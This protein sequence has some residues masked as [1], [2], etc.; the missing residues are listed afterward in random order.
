MDLSRVVAQLE[1]QRPGAR[2]SGLRIQPARLGEPLAERLVAI[3]EGLRGVVVD[4]GRDP[5]VGRELPHPQHQLR[6]LLAID[7]ERQ[8]P[9]Q[10][11]VVPEGRTPEIEAVI[12]RAELR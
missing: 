4:T 12:V 9:A 3:V 11:G 5:A 8:R 7:H 2:V 1:T 6:E 10:S